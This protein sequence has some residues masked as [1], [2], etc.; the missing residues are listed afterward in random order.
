MDYERIC[1][2]KDLQGRDLI[3]VAG[4]SVTRT[5]PL[6]SP[7]DVRR[8]LDWLVRQGPRTGLFLGASSSITPGVPWENLRT[9][10]EGLAY[11]RTHGRDS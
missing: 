11:Y 9:L 2:M 6:G 8:E 1:R 4:V 7:A 10:I 3:I 5:L